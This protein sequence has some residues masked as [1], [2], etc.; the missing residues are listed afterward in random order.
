[1]KEGGLLWHVRPDMGLPKSVLKVVGEKRGKPVFDTSVP[2]LGGEN[3][4][5]RFTE[6]QKNYPIP[7]FLGSKELSVDFFFKILFISQHERIQGTG[8]R[9]SRLPTEQRA[10]YR[11]RSQD[12]EILT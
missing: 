5:S 9:R 12:P 11:A 8:R 6:K 2:K 4:N 1:M 3:L 10:Q 7:S